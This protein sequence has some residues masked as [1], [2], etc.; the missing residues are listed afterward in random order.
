VCWLS[1]AALLVPA[2]L[3]AL[4]GAAARAPNAHRASGRIAVTAWPYLP[5][6][7]IPLRIDGFAP[8]YNVLLLGPG[9]L[10]SGGMYAIPQGSPNASAFLVAGNGAGLAAT[11]VRIAGPP[12]ANRGLLIAASY[13]DGLVFQDAENLSVLGVL[14]TGGRPSDVAVDA[15]GKIAATDTQGTALTVGTLAPWSVSH[16]EGIVLGD[17]I[18]FDQTTRAI[19]V[20]DRDVDGNGALTRVDP[21]GRVTRVATGATAEGLAVDE[22]RQVVYVANANDGTIAQVG[23]ASMRVL[24]RFRAIDRIFSLALSPD[25]TRLY[26]IS[27]ESAGSPFAAA[28]SAVEF[29]LRGPVPRVVARS[30]EL[31]F[32]LGVALDASARTLFV[33]DEAL[34]EV[35]VLDAR[36]LRPRHAPLRTCATPWKPSLDPASE[37]LY[38]P[39]A[40]ANAIDAFDARTLRRVRGAPFRTGSYPLAVAIWH[41]GRH[42]SVT[43]EVPK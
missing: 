6:S 7:L 16:I 42:G 28:G 1:R 26:G 13:D 40:G 2:V 14:A 12:P 18:A 27:N 41:P 8:P 21:D 10:L 20:T 30:G 33:T 32:P 22:R 17:E 34:G 11:T 24:R 3:V 37:R 39:C 38:V 15:S 23:A 29:R 43:V 25:G 9:Q 35:D 31:T 19:F 36:T 5:G 4:G